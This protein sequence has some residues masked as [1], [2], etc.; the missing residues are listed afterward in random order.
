MSLDQ[1]PTFATEVYWLKQLLKLIIMPTFT[2]VVVNSD[3]AD[4][5][6]AARYRLSFLFT[7]TFIADAIVAIAESSST[8]ELITFGQRQAITGL[9]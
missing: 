3:F 9:K 7:V 1:K 8:A 4:L 5:D 2:V 6:H